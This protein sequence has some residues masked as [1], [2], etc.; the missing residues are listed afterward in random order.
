MGLCGF[1]PVTAL[2]LS[3]GGGGCFSFE[4]Q[5]R[6]EAM[7]FTS[8][9]KLIFYSTKCF[10]EKQL[11]REFSHS[12]WFYFLL[13]PPNPKRRDKLLLPIRSF[14]QTC[15]SNKLLTAKVSI[16][17]RKLGKLWHKNIHETL[18]Q[19]CPASNTL[20]TPPPLYKHTIFCVLLLSIK[21]TP[22]FPSHLLSL[23]SAKET[24]FTSDNHT[25]RISELHMDLVQ[26]SATFYSYSTERCGPDRSPLHWVLDLQHAGWGS[27]VSPKYCM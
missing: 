6:R 11:K 22:S 23:Q 18:K 8:F 14:T 19:L 4:I 5:Q 15:Q 12:V 20:H 21:L 2:V 26:R 17:S 7:S 1:L 9:W 10:L 25:S 24:V 16:H 27:G 13:T 3:E